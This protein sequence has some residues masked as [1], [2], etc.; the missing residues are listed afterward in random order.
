MSANPFSL[1]PL[2]SSVFSFQPHHLIRAI[3]FTPTPSRPVFLTTTISNIYIPT[4]NHHYQSPYLSECVISK[5]SNIRG[6]SAKS[7]FS[8]LAALKVMALATAAELPDTRG[9]FRVVFVEDP[10]AA[11]TSINVPMEDGA[12]QTPGPEQPG[13]TQLTPIPANPT[14]TIPKTIAPSGRIRT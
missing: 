6:A 13:T 10:I 4:H 11:T 1:R 3:R 8:C 12:L 14:Y 5:L 2:V 9:L 7:S